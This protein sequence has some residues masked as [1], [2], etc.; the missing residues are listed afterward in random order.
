MGPTVI[1]HEKKPNCTRRHDGWELSELTVRRVRIDRPLKNTARGE[2]ETPVAI[3]PER[4]QFRFT[5]RVRRDRAL[6]IAA[7]YS[8]LASKV[9]EIVI[10]L[11][12][13]GLIRLTPLG[14][15]PD[16]PGCTRAKWSPFV[17]VERLP[18]LAKTSVHICVEVRPN[19]VPNLRWRKSGNLH[20]RVHRSA[21]QHFSGLD[22]I[23]P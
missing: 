1:S 22:V 15:L 3:D 19:D 17:P 10:Y 8:E 23:L 12:N 7:M 6:S 21:T 11:G 5:H 18:G 20:E 9:G 4:P 13:P 16:Q 2:L 14:S